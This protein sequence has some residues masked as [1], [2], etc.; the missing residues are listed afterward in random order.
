MLP[1]VNTEQW[2]PPSNYSILIRIR[3]NIQLLSHGIPHEPGPS[4]A[5]D[6]GK[7][8]I[9]LGREVLCRCELCLDGFL[10]AV[11]SM[12]HSPYSDP[13]GEFSLRFVSSTTTLGRKILPEQRVIDVSTAVKVNQRLEGHGTSGITS[14]L[15]S[16]ELLAGSIEAGDVRCVVFAV[17]QF[18]DPPRDG[19]LQGGIVIYLHDK[20]GTIFGEYNSQGRSGKVAFPRR[21]TAEH[22]VEAERIGLKARERNDERRTEV[23]MMMSNCS[24]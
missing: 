16:F 13:Y 6:T 11:N 22:E 1:G 12:R 24:R 8:G 7:L 21:E 2:T 10:N 23:A 4:A 5:L 9:E 19:G 18:H 3:A 20:P 17:V 14:S 15:G